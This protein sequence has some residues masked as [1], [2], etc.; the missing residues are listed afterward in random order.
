MTPEE[1]MRE[2]KANQWLNELHY[3]RTQ[4]VKE[5]GRS[6]NVCYIDPDVF[7]AIKEL[8]YHEAPEESPA[9]ILGMRVAF[10]KSPYPEDKCIVLSRVENKCVIH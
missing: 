10:V 7:K 6:P 5:H 8:L 4:F 9:E 2:W 3:R 1:Q